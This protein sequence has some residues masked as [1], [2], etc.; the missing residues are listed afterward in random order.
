MA[1]IVLGLDIGG[2]NLKAATSAGRALTQPFAVW[3]EPHILTDQIRRLVANFPETTEVA[4]T[5]TAELCDCYETKLDGVTRIVQAIL[6]ATNP[7]PLKLWSV[8]QGLVLPDFAITNYMDV[9]SANWHALATV[10]G[11]YAPTG[12]ALLIDC[13][14][15]TTD[16]IPLKNGKPFSRGLTDV[17]RLK[18]GELVYTGWRRTPATTLLGHSKYAAEFFATTLDAY[19]VLGWIEDNVMD[20]DTADGRPATRANALARL[21][22]MKCADTHILA[23]NDIIDIAHH[24]STL[25]RNILFE[26]IIH[27][28]EDLHSD[29]SLRLIVSGSGAFLVHKIIQDLHSHIVILQKQI[30]I[31][32][33]SLDNILG[34]KIS[35]AAAAYAVA[36]LASE[37]L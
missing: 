33:L 24:V 25:Q 1:K 21:A 18:Y 20:C 13:G 32:S 17:D 30:A 37:R 29:T 8:K 19:L 23:D 35:E 22:R 27:H 36:V 9:A 15:T 12:P 11:R 28:F 4:A 7:L 26:S 34:Y 31:S 3:K 5:M 10:A 2:A 6:D 16:L 14:T